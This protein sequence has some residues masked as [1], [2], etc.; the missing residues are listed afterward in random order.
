MAKKIKSEIA[1]RIKNYNNR[2]K[3]KPPVVTY[4]LPVDNIWE[5]LQ[6][7]KNLNQ[8]KVVN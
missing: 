1:V 2:L 8:Y 4:K 6:S 7:G 3:E 5:T